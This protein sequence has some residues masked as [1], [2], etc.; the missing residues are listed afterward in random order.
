MR[1]CPTS[2]VSLVF[3]G[4]LPLSSLVLPACEPSGTGTPPTAPIS[5]ASASS[6][7]SAPA[8]ATAPTA[9]PAV[10]DAGASESTLFV[11]ENVVDCEGEGPRKCLRVRAS[12]S[13]PFQ[14]FYGKIEGFTHEPGTAFELRVVVSDREMP[15][16]DAPAKR[17]R[18]VQVVSKRKVG[19]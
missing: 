2:V 6:S 8:T 14:L 1:P 5:S 10:T 16:S 11:A 12:E 13:E 19:K 3:A 18:L 15:P 7:A 17:Y 9:S 4:L